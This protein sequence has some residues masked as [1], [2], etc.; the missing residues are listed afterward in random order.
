MALPTS[1]VLD[2]SDIQTE[3]GGSNPISLSEYY[4][5]GSYVPSG[6][7]GTNGAV[8]TSGEIAVSDF[9]GTQSGITITVTEGTD[10]IVNHDG[11]TG[12]QIYGW[13]HRNYLPRNDLAALVASAYTVTTGSRSPTSINGANITGLLWSSNKYTQPR[14]YLVLQGTHTQSFVTSLNI[15]GYGTV[16][17]A[18]A[19]DF[20]SGITGN[21]V[22]ATV[23]QW[24]ISPTGW[25]G[26]GTST[27]TI[28]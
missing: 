17:T 25:D 22:T 9:Y 26:S 21:G 7:S 18:A 5:G 16:T 20:A 14:F 28:A 13:Y 12:A 23:W 27:V 6:T 10:N 24:N 1:G 4:A 19:D 2:L 11:S 8:P 15:Q 3:F